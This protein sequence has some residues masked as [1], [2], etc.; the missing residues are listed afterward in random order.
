MEEQQLPPEEEKEVQNEPAV[1]EQK[2]EDVD[3]P[4]EGK[5]EEID[6][7][8]NLHERTIAALSYFGFL[9]IVPFYLK[10]DSKFCR[11]HGKQGLTLAIVFFLAKFVS[12][13]DLIMD[14]A[15]VLQ[16]IIALWMGFAALSGRWK[17]L[18]VIYKWSCQLEESLNLK[19]KDEE[20]NDAA[21]KPNQVKV[22]EEADE[23]P[24]EEPK[25]SE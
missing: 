18:P 6:E 23:K 22:E 17:K 8:T 5:E 25:K 15:L 20:A 1:E 3:A 9:A 24:A 7:M 4:P 16:A 10:K 21:L 12:V 2:P 13:L 19:T 14:L 11:F